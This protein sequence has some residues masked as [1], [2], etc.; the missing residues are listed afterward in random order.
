[1]YYISENKKME[2]GINLVYVNLHI[3]NN[4]FETE[5]R[6]IP[7]YSKNL[8]LLIIWKLWTVSYFVTTTF[9]IFDFF[10]SFTKTN[11]LFNWK[12]SSHPSTVGGEISFN[13]FTFGSESFSTRTIKFHA[14]LCCFSSQNIYWFDSPSTK[15][16]FW[17][18]QWSTVWRLSY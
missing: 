6:Y 12:P 8:F 2:T 4:F 13:E 16:E 11:Y 3:H 18:S 10:I 14:I 15:R 5:F 7:V 17:N 1:M 9:S